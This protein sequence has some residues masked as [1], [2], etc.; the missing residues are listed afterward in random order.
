MKLRPCALAVRR[1]LAAFLLLSPG[2]VLLSACSGGDGSTA[3]NPTDLPAPAGDAP[4]ARA[5]LL[6][7]EEIEPA[8][9]VVAEIVPDVPPELVRAVLAEIGERAR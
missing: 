4:F 6:D 7:V 5:L 2:I 3:E 9:D 8:T 1:T